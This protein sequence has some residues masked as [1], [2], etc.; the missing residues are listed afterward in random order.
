MN[1]WGPK[2]NTEYFSWF[3]LLIAER[4]EHFFLRKKFKKK[5][6][7]LLV[8]IFAFICI[9]GGGP[10]NANMSIYGYNY[11]FLPPSTYTILFSSFSF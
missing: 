4:K 8:V 2:K 9:H 11:L 5:R 3:V 10:T 6:I 1:E 7:L